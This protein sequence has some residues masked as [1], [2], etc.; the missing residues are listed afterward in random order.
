MYDRIRSASISLLALT[1]IVAGCG[2][3]DP[4]GGIP[5]DFNPVEIGGSVEALL[6]PAGGIAAPRVALQSAFSFLVDQGLTFDRVGDEPAGPFVPGLSVPGRG[7][8]AA[9]V[10]IPAGLL[11]QTVVFDNS[12]QGQGWVVDSARTG[13]PANGVRIIWYSIDSAGNLIQPLTEQ[14]YVD[15]TDEDDGTGSRIGIEMVATAG[16]GNT[17]LADFTE[18]LDSTSTG[19][20]AVTDFQAAG[21]FRGAGET[22]DFSVD[23]E[24]STD[25]LS[26]DSDI[27]I[28]VTLDGT[29]GV[30]TLQI[31]GTESG[32]D[33][34]IDQAITADMVRAGITTV[35]NLD[36]SVSGTGAQSGTGNLV[37]DGSSVVDIAID[38][39]DFQYTE[40]GGDRLG[41]GA[42]ADVD[43]LVRAL[44]LTGLD[45]LLRLPLLFL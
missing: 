35:L 42:S 25:T 36:L 6:Q 21:F 18:R 15:L 8:I 45:A 27:L 43:Y 31:D 11:G 26:G 28:A 24:V 7:V 19:T 38:G 29:E 44:Y 33:G 4:V 41:G 22:V 32:S 37:H 10:E 2:G 5:D 17:V 23:Y 9:A 30:Y 40:P 1:V 14:G 16:S 12:E 20:A 13:A 34:A 39:T 3:D